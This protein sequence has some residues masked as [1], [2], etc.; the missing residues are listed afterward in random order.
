[1]SERIRLADVAEYAGV[2]TAT[3]SR[4]LNGKSSVAATTRQAVLT[5]LDLLGYERPEKLRIR[6]GGLIGL[7]VPELT[8]PI[9]PLIVQRLEKEMSAQGYTPVLCAQSAGGTTEDQYVQ[10]LLDQHV[11]GIIFV[12][13]LHADTT[14]DPARYRALMDLG[15]PFVTING[16]NP[17]IPVADFSSDDEEAVRQMVRQL[18]VAGHRKIGLATG[19]E[20]FRP[21]LDKVA[22]YRGG[23]AE[24]CPGQPERIVHTLFTVEG[25]QSAASQLL[26]AGVTA[27]ICGSDLMALGAIRQVRREGLRVP[28]DVSVIGYDDSGICAYT[29]PPLTTVHQPIDAI[30][31]AAVTTLMSMITGSRPAQVPMFFQCKLVFRGS[32]AAAPG[33][34][35]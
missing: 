2:S 25:G 33:T 34:E 11:A 31:S 4:V 13:G 8:N 30:T 18:A 24:H 21:A 27:I 10:I 12:S 20:R 15:I 32:T 14:A 19:P 1:M 26:S 6:P 5:A 29:D 28:E 35:D 17:D 22:G 9:F 16:R 23:M 3:V 7:I